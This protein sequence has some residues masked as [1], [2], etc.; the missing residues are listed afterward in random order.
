MS[1]QAHRPRVT[2]NGIRRMRTHRYFWCQHCQRTIRI[3]SSNPYTILCPYCS[4]E[5][6]HELDVS[7][8]RLADHLIT[9]LEQPPSPAAR[10]LE[11]LSLA[12]DSRL[13]RAR[14]QTEN[15]DERLS[16]ITL[17]FDR[18]PRT[19]RL[20]VSASSENVVPRPNYNREDGA[21]EDAVRDVT[22]ET[23]T[24]ENDRPG[25]PPAATS[26][27]RALPLV[28]VSEGQLANEPSCPV[29]KEAF[30]IGGEVRET[31]CK[32]VYHS[33]CILPWLHIHNT[34]PVC[35]YELRAA[36]SC[37]PNDDY[38]GDEE[39]VTESPNIWGWWNHFISFWP[40]SALVNWTQRYLDNQQRTG[41][42]YIL[43]VS[44]NLT[45]L[46][47]SYAFDLRSGDLA[48]LDAC[49]LRLRRLWVLDLVEDNELEA[50]GSNCPLLEELRAFACHPDI[51]IREVTE[52]GF[53]A[54]SYMAAENSAASSIYA[55]SSSTR[56][57]KA[58]GE[59]HC[60]LKGCPK[61]KKLEIR[62]CPFGNVDLLSGIEKYESVRSLWISAC[63]V[64]MAPCRLLASDGGNYDQG[65]PRL[66]ISVS[67]DSKLLLYV[68]NLTEYVNSITRAETC[69]GGSS[70][71]EVIE[72]LAANWERVLLRCLKHVCLINNGLAFQHGC[73]KTCQEYVASAV[74]NSS[75]PRFISKAYAVVTCE[76]NYRQ[77]DR[78]MDD[79]DGN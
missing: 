69:F 64:T 72:S 28:T 6:N 77:G 17:R 13:P 16:W 59:R 68:L 20:Q 50:V 63:N 78:V 23:W 66:L 29:C 31:P 26:A 38:Y 34:C 58:F 33:D 60:V 1:L 27:I 19:P 73:R 62:E 35:R 9:G 12:L 43:P 45:F 65:M 11:S 61:L 42:V 56:R 32:H 76:A 75:G 10:L 7:N 57:K 21:F 71:R 22:G 40:F 39:E 18:P 3:A 36:G 25:P 49:C 44:E 8:P 51:I 46:D 37:N 41:V 24:V 55:F 74:M 53:V 4:T 70:D 47:L 79:E 48:V 54:V 30:E 67:E 52:P 14:W 2:V 15:E 5:F